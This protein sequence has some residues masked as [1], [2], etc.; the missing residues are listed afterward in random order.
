MVGRE[1]MGHAARSFAALRA[2]LDLSPMPMSERTAAT[3]SAP[4]PERAGSDPPVTNVLAPLD[5]DVCKRAWGVEQAAPFDAVVSLNMV[6][7]APWAASSGLFEGA[8]RLLRPRGIL[9]LYGPFM[10]EGG[11]TAPSN[12]AFDASLKARNPAWGLRDIAELEA[13]GESRDSVSATRSR[14]RPTICRWS[15]LGVARE[16]R[17]ADSIGQYE[18]RRRSQVHR[19]NRGLLKT[20]GIWRRFRT[21]DDPIKL[22]DRG[23]RRPRGRAPC[24][25]RARG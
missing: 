22:G 5:I 7:I 19:A 1:L 15:S 18:N 9:L 14:C 16:C 11:H 6:H 4:T 8:G 20:A 13:L 10:R 12:A 25:V 23:D 17:S 2:S 21:D 3:P 24:E